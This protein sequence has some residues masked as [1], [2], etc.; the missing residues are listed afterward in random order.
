MNRL[1]YSHLR[2]SCLLLSLGFLLAS[3]RDTDVVEALPVTVTV[4]YPSTYAVKA[5]AGITV[6]LESTTGGEKLPAQTTDANGTVRFPSVLPGTYTVSATQT[7]SATDAERITNVF[8]QA[9]TL[10]A[11]QRSVSITASS[12]QTIPLEL[13]G[14]PAGTLLIKEVYYTA[15]KTPNNGNY[16]SDQFVEIYNNSDST[17]ALDGLCIADVYG[18]SGQI[19]PNS[20][21][22]DFKDDTRHVYLNSVWRIPG[23]GRQHLLEPGKS[24]LIAQDGINHQT[25]PAGNPNS[26]VNLANADWE[27]YN[28]RPDNR[29][30]D[31]PSVPNLERVY[32]TGGFDWLLPVFGPGLV[33][34]RTSDFNTLEKVAI[35][36]AASLEPRIKLPIGQIIDAFEG[37]QDANSGAFKRIPTSVDAGFVFASGTYTSESFRRKTATTFNGRRVL[38]DLNNSGSDF[39]KLSKPTPRSFQ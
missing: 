26:P 35:P 24:I 22:T 28:Q 8:R 11:V 33:I 6:T 21:P 27:T 13:A 39:E 5:G 7:L 18:V 31:S 16:F 34:F 23:T 4:S 29:D 1:F 9:L 37:L 14:A 19:N 20:T 32:F 30:T 3:C 12:N 17:I 15:S 2:L 38:Q 36:S 25:D 10:N